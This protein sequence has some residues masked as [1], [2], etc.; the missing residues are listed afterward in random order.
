MTTSASSFVGPDPTEIPLALSKDLSDAVADGAEAADDGT[1]PLAILSDV[2]AGKVA[3]LANSSLKKLVP[4]PA[5]QVVGT[6]LEKIDGAAP[7]KIVIPAGNLPAE[8]ASL[9]TQVNEALDFDGISVSTGPSEH[10]RERVLVAQH[11]VQ[12][13]RD[14]AYVGARPAEAV[15][16]G[17]P[18][19]F[20]A[21]N[22]A[23]A[24][25]MVPHETQKK[26]GLDALAASLRENVDGNPKVLVSTVLQ[27]AASVT[28]NAAC[29]NPSVNDFVQRI[30]AA[31]NGDSKPLASWC[32]QNLKNFDELA[33]GDDRQF[34]ASLVDAFKRYRDKC[35]SDRLKFASPPAGQKYGETLVNSN[36][37]G[38]SAS[39]DMALLTDIPVPDLVSPKTPAKGPDKVTKTQERAPQPKKSLVDKDKG[40]KGASTPESQGGVS[41]ETKEFCAANRAFFENLEKKEA[42]TIPALV[43]EPPALPSA[44]IGTLSISPA[45]LSQARQH[46]KKCDFYQLY[47]MTQE[48]FD[49]NL[50]WHRRRLENLESDV[51]SV[52]PDILLGLQK[53]R[54]E[55]AAADLHAAQEEHGRTGRNALNVDKAN[56]HFIAELEFYDRLSAKAASLPT[57]EA[58]ATGR[59]FIQWADEKEAHENAQNRAGK[60]A[61]PHRVTSKVEKALKEVSNGLGVGR[62]P[63]AI[64]E[65]EGFKATSHGLQAERLEKRLDSA[66]PSR[67][68]FSNPEKVL[69]WSYE[70]IRGS[71]AQRKTE[72][73]KNREADVGVDL[74]TQIAQQ[75]QVVDKIAAAYEAADAVALDP[76]SRTRRNEL[77]C[78]YV[79][80]VDFLGGLELQKAE[81]D[82]SARPVVSLSD[83]KDASRRL[84]EKETKSLP[85]S[86]REKDFHEHDKDNHAPEKSDGA[87]QKK[88]PSPSKSK[89]ESPDVP[90]EGIPVVHNNEGADQKEGD[91]TGEGPQKEDTSKDQSP[92]PTLTKIPDIQA[93]GASSSIP[94]LSS[95]GAAAEPSTTY[96]SLRT[97]SS[98]TPNLFFDRQGG[99]MNMHTPFQP[100][101]A[102]L[103]NAQSATSEL[104]GRG[105]LFPGKFECQATGKVTFKFDNPQESSFNPQMLREFSRGLASQRAS[106]RADSRPLPAAAEPAASSAPSAADQSHNDFRRMPREDPHLPMFMQKALCSVFAKTQNALIGAHDLVCNKQFD[107]DEKVRTH[108]R[109]LEEIE[110][111]LPRINGPSQGS[112]LWVLEHR[113]LAGPAREVLQS[114]P[115]ILSDRSE[116]A[117]RI[118]EIY[119]REHELHER[120]EQQTEK[121]RVIVRNVQRVGFRGDIEPDRTFTP[122]F[123]EEIEPYLITVERCEGARLKELRDEE[124]RIV[125]KFVT[126]ELHALAGTLP[127]RLQANVEHHSLYAKGVLELTSGTYSLAPDSEAFKTLSRLYI[128]EFVD[129]IQNGILKEEFL[130]SENGR[131]FRENLWKAYTDLVEKE[132]LVVAAQQEHSQLGFGW[133]AIDWM[134]GTPNVAKKMDDLKGS[135]E[136]VVK[137]MKQLHL[138]IIAQELEKAPE[139]DPLVEAKKS[140][141]A[142]L[143]GEKVDERRGFIGTVLLPA[144]GRGP[145][146]FPQ[147]EAGELPDERRWLRIGVPQTLFFGACENP[148]SLAAK[149]IVFE[150]R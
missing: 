7:R 110:K 59:T 144:L 119:H 147:A 25:D 41:E 111:Q 99:S 55:N 95:L 48:Q 124:S 121:Y 80:E 100:R 83:T 45:V 32:L 98:P 62:D 143:K 24:I 21:S 69:G 16:E 78:Q 133:R 58:P 120:K 116:A 39:Q 101:E 5:V 89:K 86:E 82:S 47:G 79:A 106:Q 135:V 134:R 10:S 87:D 66:L 131:Q 15:L 114:N 123:L 6:V 140:L 43:E 57:G 26:L 139:D 107:H 37:Q 103:L 72:I 9:L 130:R 67:T 63:K 46:A 20:V 2:V 52:D 30:A 35:E 22:L 19:T 29:L 149:L 14:V 109:K 92:F 49:E 77:L 126:P 105:A 90:E 85:A 75:K 132:A 50:K 129:T 122:Q 91:Q 11:L 61:H 102:R 28:G 81:V 65:D 125:E 136:V 84:H 18:T 117:K 145:L 118:L 1:P 88:P 54:V 70:Q 96:S 13:F 42:G 51:Q 8:D 44:N 38:Q 31:S 97:F 40:Q 94:S 60:H 27:G 64:A 113:I 3:D 138:N 17:A 141:L 128:H 34:E 33:N 76:Q 23:D 148:E 36:S 71:I 53:G 104:F 112:P 73:Q 56:V 137:H 108:L 150:R 93:K 146:Y 115:H 68:Y 142:I 12:F 127:A 4:I 74:V